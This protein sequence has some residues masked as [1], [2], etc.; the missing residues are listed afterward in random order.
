M[1]TP[2]ND[3]SQPESKQPLSDAPRPAAPQPYQPKPQPQASANGVY[4]TNCGQYNASWRSTCER[5][6]TQLVRTAA[7]RVPPTG[8]PGQAR[9]GYYAS[10]AGYSQTGHT[11]YAYGYARERPGCLTAY[12]ILMVIATV[13]IVFLT[14]SLTSSLSS[15]GSSGVT[16]IYTLILIGA[17][18]YNFIAA[19][20]I[21]NLK[22]WGRIMVMIGIG[23]SI[24][25]NVLQLCTALSASSSSSQGT[26]IGTIIGI[27]LASYVFYWFYNN[28]ELFE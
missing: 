20:G 1:D 18:I 3:Q 26:L 23:L 10:A 14:L 27:P 4:C 21:W 24:A 12:V 13:G 2:P 11:S 15:Y 17:A 8:Q 9:S 19:Y 28:G 22:N 7:A 5:C 25:S 16:G 6:S